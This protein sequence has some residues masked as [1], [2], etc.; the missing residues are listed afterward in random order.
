MVNGLHIPIWNRTEKSL[1]IAL[2]GVGIGLYNISLIG[3][4]IMNPPYNEYILIK[5]YIYI[6]IER[7]YIYWIYI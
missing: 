1:A 3:I 5:I 2:S 4:V 7:E 6:N